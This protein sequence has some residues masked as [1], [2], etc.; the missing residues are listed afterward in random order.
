MRND[1]TGLP[2][3]WTPETEW[4]EV[5]QTDGVA[6]VWMNRPEKRNALTVGMRRD[7]ASALRF[8]G[9]GQRARGIILTGCGRA[10]SSGEDL[11]AVAEMDNE[12]AAVAVETFHD[13]TLACLES[14]VPTVAAVNGLAVGGA[15]EMTL[16]FDNRIGTPDAGFFL[17]ENQRGL[18]ISNAASL[19]LYRLMRPGNVIR[20]VLGAQRLV[21]QEAEKAGLLDEIVEH[22]DLI[23][24][25]VSLIKAWTAPETITRAQLG[26]LRPA[27][28]AVRRAMAEE[29]RVATQVRNSRHVRD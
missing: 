29:S 12:T 27:P 4:I 20:F 19:L 26:L 21:G 22:T 11:S 3:D 17:P 1:H 6:I 8:Y 14:T 5:T 10:F 18:V 2:D 23:E 13:I 25:A 15:C 16:C 24:A 7:I 9:T 28:D